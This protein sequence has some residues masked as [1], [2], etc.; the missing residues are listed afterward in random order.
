MCSPR[1][2]FPNY[3]MALGPNA[4]AGS[5]GFTIGNQTATIARIVREVCLFLSS[6]AKLGH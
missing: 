2:Q 4:V 3:F 6:R 1:V 5:W